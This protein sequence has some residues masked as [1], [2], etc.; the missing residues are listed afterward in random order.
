MIT[1]REGKS[2]PEIFAERGEASFRALEAEVLVL[3]EGKRGHVVATGG[4]F[5]CQSGVMERLRALGTVVWLAADFEALYQRASRAGSRPML[6]GRTRDDVARLYEARRAYYR[7]AQLAIDTT[8]LG[9]DQV[10]SRIQRHLRARG[11]PARAGAPAAAGPATRG[12]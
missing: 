8:L 6:A 9:V 4:G 1:A 11:W 3:L 10:V 12:S 5:P 2:I 7:Q